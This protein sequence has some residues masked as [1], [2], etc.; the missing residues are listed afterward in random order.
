MGIDSASEPTRFYK[1]VSLDAEGRVLDVLTRGTLLY[2]CPLDFNDPFDCS[3]FIPPVPQAQ[4]STDQRRLLREKSKQLGWSGHKFVRDKKILLARLNN[5]VNSG[6]YLRMTMQQVGV[7][8]MTTDPRDI[9]MWSHYADFHRG[10]IVEFRVDLDGEFVPDPLNPK[11]LVPH[12]VEY[13]DDRP[14]MKLVSNMASIGLEE[15]RGMSSVFLVK[16]P[17][18][19]YEQEWRHVDVVRGPGVHP[20]TVKKHLVGVIAGARMPDRDLTRVKQAMRESEDAFGCSLTFHRA[21]LRHDIY[22]IE[23]PGH[24]SESGD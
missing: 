24:H 22:A 8:S 16:S 15:R 12:P 3:P 21:Q 10:F 17:H 9:L 5:A 7:C 13:R 19:K 4:L 20:Y 18:W 23:I 11:D 14:Q 1:Y 2:R 6:N